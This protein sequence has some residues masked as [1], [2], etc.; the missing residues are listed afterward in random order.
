MRISQRT[1][2]LESLG[3]EH[4]DG[5]SWL[6]TPR[7]PK[8]Y[9]EFAGFD[10]GRPTWDRAG[11]IALTRVKDKFEKDTVQDGLAPGVVEPIDV[12]D[13]FLSRQSVTTLSNGVILHAQ[14]GLYEH[15]LDLLA[16]RAVRIVSAMKFDIVTNVSSSKPLA[17]DLAK[18]IASHMS[19]QFIPSGVLKTKDPSRVTAS[20]E[21]DKTIGKNLDRFKRAI[22]KGENPSVRKTFHA[23]QRAQVRGYLEPSMDAL[24]VVTD[25]KRTT[26]PRVLV[27]DDILT[28]GSAAREAKS[29]LEAIGYDVVAII[30]AF[31]ADS[32]RA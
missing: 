10:L 32:R 11:A 3:L 28:T 12:L 26:A 4:L 6:V 7:P 31:R 22:E 20:K 2:I 30:A 16:Q 27:V 18:A 1:A 15:V 29:E 19:K 21:V 24:D 14:E 23:R 13:F 25:P 8:G 9:A 17:G 5:E